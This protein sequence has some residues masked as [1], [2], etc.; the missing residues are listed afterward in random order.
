M[1]ARAACSVLI[2]WLIAGVATAQTPLFIVH[3]ETGP[4]WDESRAATEQ[5]A[6]REHSANLNRLRK[7]GVIKFGAR[8][9]K[10]GM[11]LIHAA[12]LE[13]ARTIIDADPGVQSG[14]F[15]YEIA[16]LSVFYRWQD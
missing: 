12:S 6:F 7:E 13:A 3:F 9:E 4:H 11:I 14:I 8:Y 2:L 15:I 10:V 5:P 1:T 16:P